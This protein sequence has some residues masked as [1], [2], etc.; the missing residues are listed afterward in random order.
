MFKYYLKKTSAA[1]VAA[2]LVLSMG[3]ARVIHADTEE[4]TQDTEITEEVSEG[5]DATEAANGTTDG[6]TPLLIATQ[7]NTEG[8]LIATSGDAGEGTAVDAGVYVKKIA[9]SDDFYTGVDVSSYLSEIESGVKYY[10][11]EG[12]LLDEVGF[13]KLLADNGINSVRLRVWNDPYDATGKGYGGGNCDI[14][15]VITMG[16]YATEAGL[17]VLIDFHYS[18]FWADPSK[19]N[20]PKAWADMDLT[21]KTKALHDYTYDSV[22]KLKDAG[23][24]V[25]MVQVGNETTTGMCG[26]TDWTSVCTLIKAGCDAVHEVDPSILRAV[27]FTDAEDNKYYAYARYLDNNSVDYEVFASS[28]YPYW[29]GDYENLATQLHNVADNF[30]KKVMVVETSYAYTLDDGDG[31]GN[32]IGEGT[33]GA[34]MRYTVSEQGQVNLVHDVTEVVTSFGKLGIGVFWWE[35]AWIPVEV[36]KDAGGTGSYETNMALWEKYGSGW[37]TSASGEYDEDAATWFGGSAVDNQA[38]FDF[39]GHPLE[40][41]KVFNYIRTGTN[42]PFGITDIKVDPVT[43]GLTEEIKMPENAILYYTDGST[44]EIPVAWAINDIEDAKNT[45][46]GVYEIRGDIIIGDGEFY[47]ITCELRLNSDNLLTNPGFE[48]AS[49][50]AWKITDDVNGNK[51]C[52]DRKKDS[53]N[54]RTGEYCLHFWD[55]E[56]INYK[57]EQTVYLKKGTYKLGTWIEGGDAGADPEFKLYAKTDTNTYEVLTGVTSWQQYQNPEIDDIV[58]EEDGMAL[59]IGISVKAA[60]GAWG[61][62]DDFYLYSTSEGGGIM[63]GMENKT[64]E[65]TVE[66]ADDN[67]KDDKDTGSVKPKKKKHLSPAAMIAAFVGGGVVVLGVLVAIITKA[68]KKGGTLGG[69]SSD[70]KK[71]DK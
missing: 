14:D 55:D 50:G 52:V 51:P 46:A 20:A 57:V 21:T 32:T 9:L 54:V 48:D 4:S 15:R 53:S 43:Y 1:V 68:K 19:Q 28:Y 6:D 44:E 45:G 37:A 17:R 27:H 58:I 34:D 13:F 12:N 66:P 29:H 63:P 71:D 40:T 47:E 61:A 67:K 22:K 8:L 39:S 25:T 41:L 69:D 7:D 64:T 31:T 60:K 70:D 5:D 38:F 35:P 33:S 3:T 36:V 24:N 30:N 11:F 65:D 59:T 42:A 2:A 23:V 16:K 56:D 49:M 18:D 10:D 62:W 26:E